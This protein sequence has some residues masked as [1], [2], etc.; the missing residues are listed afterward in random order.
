MKSRKTIELGEGFNRRWL[1]YAAAAGAA[2]T[3]ASIANADIITTH[4]DLPFSF[5]APGCGPPYC[6]S[7]LASVDL[8]HD[9][10]NDFRLSGF[11]QYDLDGGA[12]A[13]LFSGS[14]G[15]GVMSNAAALPKGKAIGPQGTFRGKASMLLAGADFYRPY[16]GGIA[17]PWRGSVKTSGTCSRAYACN[18]Y[19]NVPDAYLG[20]QF[21]INGEAHYG[22]A[23][24]SLSSFAANGEAGLNGEITAFAYETAA[25]QGLDAGQTSD[26]PEPGTVGLLAVGSLGLGFWRRRKAVDSRQ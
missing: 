25:N 3:T 17:G 10:L 24:L 26:T 19:G 6:F 20:L 1:G 23:E 13:L 5:S 12:V 15:G 4:V 22:W 9:G 16:D 11:G 18:R 8:N 2:L 14:G 7:V 21:Y